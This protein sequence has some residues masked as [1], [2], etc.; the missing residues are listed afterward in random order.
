MHTLLPSAAPT[1][2]TPAV[3]AAR[4]VLTPAV[5]A[6]QILGEDDR[7]VRAVADEFGVYLKPSSYGM[8][9]KPLVKEACRCVLCWACCIW[10]LPRLCAGLVLHGTL[11]C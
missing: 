10:S 4:A 7:S 6:T 1:A 5:P 9:V 8:D 2:L 3:P 11:R